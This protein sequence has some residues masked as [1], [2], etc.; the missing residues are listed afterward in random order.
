MI[1]GQQR[2]GIGVCLLA[3]LPFPAFADRV[4]W[5][6]V[7]GE[8]QLLRSGQITCRQEVR[9]CKRMILSCS[10]GT[11][12]LFTVDDFAD[13]IAA[14]DDGQ[15]IVGLSNRGSENAFWIRNSQGE[16]IERKTHLLGTHYWLGIHYCSES[17]T[18]V[19]EWF[20]REHPDVR[21]QLRNGKLVQVEVRSCDGKD[22]RLLK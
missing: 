11:K 13:Y 12:S 20:D 8:P 9:D 22:L 6:C 3:L 19:R 1:S 21:F 10:R 18:N 4:F 15:Y 7:Y 17:V 16:V 14:S 5:G 2:R